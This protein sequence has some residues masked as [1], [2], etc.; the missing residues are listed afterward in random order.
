MLQIIAL[1]HSV[2]IALSPWGYGIAQGFW[3]TPSARSMTIPAFLFFMREQSVCR[4]SADTSSAWLRFLVK[5][6]RGF[7]RKWRC[8]SSRVAAPIFLIYA[9]AIVGQ[10]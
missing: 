7:V 1:T 3:D 2:F 5:L 8:P 6:Q 10:F 4:P 9:G